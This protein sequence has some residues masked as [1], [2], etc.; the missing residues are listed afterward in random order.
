ME[1]VGRWQQM[2]GNGGKWW[3]MVGNGGQSSEL[4]LKTLQHFLPVY[5]LQIGKQTFRVVPIW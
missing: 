1:M 5:N 3:E 4:R 2:V